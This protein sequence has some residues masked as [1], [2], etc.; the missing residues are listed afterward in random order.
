MNPNKVSPSSNRAVVFSF[1]SLGFGL[2]K[3][4][5]VFLAEGLAEL[6]W[7]VDLVTVQL[8]FLSQL[9]RVPRLTCVPR[10]QRNDWL[11]RTPRMSNFVWVPAIH[12][13][14]SRSGFIDRLTTPIFRLY[15]YLLP[16]TIRQRARS[17]RLIVI[18]NSSAALLYPVLKRLSPDAKFIYLALD[19]MDA[20]G[21]HPVIKEFENKTASDYDLFV[22][23]SKLLL[24]A[25]PPSVR[26]CFLPQ[27]LD[28]ALFD[29]PVA[30]PFED[31]GPHAIVAGD[32]M[33]DRVSFEMMVR[34]FPKVTFHA[35]GCMDL[36]DLYRYQNLVYHGEVPF[37][38]LR[39]YIVHADFGIA[40]YLDRPD[41]HYLGES[42][43]K[44]VQYTYARL[45]I[46]APY[47]C[48]SGRDHIKDYRPGDETSIVRAV[49]EALL[50]D[51]R[52]IDTSVVRDWN[53]ITAEMLS[54]VD[55]SKKSGIAPHEEAPAA[56]AGA[57]GRI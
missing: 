9:A 31:G 7:Q 34:N 48:K 29:L 28:K 53:E 39:S 37:E 4:T 11:E 6:G 25:Y 22:S 51:H 45:P 12:P 43:L 50:V 23:P 19:S 30:S 36:G 41:V 16:K 54:K 35:F 8:S 1:H 32:M 17:A 20:I 3:S 56:F 33:F 49:E 40:P 47:F 46:L 18:E 24:Q 5:T 55:I 27:G 57:N 13:A 15:P 38:V 44:L 42:S 2:R 21:M 52:T 10:H 26:K 14:T